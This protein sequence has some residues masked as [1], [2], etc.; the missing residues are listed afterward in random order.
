ML[1]SLPCAL[2]GVLHFLACLL[3]IASTRYGIGLYCDVS[4]SKR[5][6]AM[7][8]WY[9]IGAST[10]Q[11]TPPK[12][13][14]LSTRPASKSS[15]S[16]A[17]TK[18]P[19]PSRRSMTRSHV[20]RQLRWTDSADCDGEVVQAKRPTPQPATL[21]PNAPAENQILGRQG[22]TP[23][24]TPAEAVNFGIVEE[25]ADKVQGSGREQGS[26]ITHTA[27][28]TKSLPAN[29]SALWG[30][31]ATSHSRFGMQAAQPR[32]PDLVA[33][34]AVLPVL[35][36]RHEIHGAASKPG[37]SNLFPVAASNLPPVSAVTLSGSTQP[38][39]KGVCSDVNE[40]GGLVGD[41]LELYYYSCGWTAVDVIAYR[42]GSD[43]HRVRRRM[44]RREHWANLRHC[45]VRFAAGEDEVE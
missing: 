28:Q 24:K 19:R 1:H 25:S 39:G 41:H 12:A 13:R 31:A 9:G 40:T 35:D 18:A 4:C 14:P 11:R 3:P 26:H 36:G 6:G 44:D 32:Q 43:E 34:L 37:P 22:R 21:H 8:R 38:S 17:S 33:P 2:P 15:S 29:P 30:A 23:T 45:R 5:V 10:S 7:R 27:E 42:P 16:K 20:A